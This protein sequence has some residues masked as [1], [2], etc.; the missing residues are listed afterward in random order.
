MRIRYA[1][2]TLQVLRKEDFFTY[3]NTMLDDP[4]QAR[5]DANVH[6]NVPPPRREW[7]A[8]GKIFFKVPISL[9]FFQDDMC[10][11]LDIQGLTQKL[12]IDIDFEP[13]SQLIQVNGSS[14]NIFLSDSSAYFNY[15]YLQGEFY[16]VLRKERDQGIAMMSAPDGV[17]LL[18][19]ATQ[20]HTQS[21]L[22][23]TAALDGTMQSFELKNLSMP[24]KF[25]I[26]LLRWVGD[27]SRTSGAS[28]PSDNFGTNGVMGGADY[29]NIAG[30]LAPLLTPVP[31]TS[32]PAV[33]LI[34]HIAL[35]SGSNYIL[36]KTPVQ[37]IINDYQGRWFKGTPGSGMLVIPLSH[38]PTLPNACTSF[39]DF[40]LID[41][42]TLDIYKSSSPNGYATVGAYAQADIGDV[43][44]G[45]YIDCVAYCH[46][47]IDI[48]SYDLHRPF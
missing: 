24:T 36:R 29:F 12:T 33:P 20:W 21:K 23:S 25:L 26:I 37:E 44:S 32:G 11:A 2:S 34:S 35:R 30:W 1:T 28:G 5:E 40:S 41:T 48:Q 3:H 7:E 15:L 10:K 14:N 19:D 38:L 42:P 13:A 43:N 18:Y 9:A 16:Q 47:N 17:R 46:D 22:D 27:L 4:A 39:L 31:D 8:K 45:L 6:G